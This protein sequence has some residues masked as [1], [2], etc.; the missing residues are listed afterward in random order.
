[1]ERMS[2]TGT[3]RSPSELASAI[4]KLS[5]SDAASAEC[6]DMWVAWLLQYGT[7]GY[8]NR[9]GSSYDAR[10][11]YNHLQNAGALL[12]LAEA[13]GVEAHAVLAARAAV[14]EKESPAAQAAAVRQH[15]PWSTI[16]SLLW[17]AGKPSAV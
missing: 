7:P 2:T 13:A 14:S 4:E 6:K 11:A 15:V 17:A 12:W 5:A 1:M 16:E 10:F 9:K 8:Y 3:T